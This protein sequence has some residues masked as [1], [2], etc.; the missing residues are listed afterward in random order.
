MSLQVD[1]YSKIATFQFSIFQ[2]SNCYNPP[3]IL[4]ERKEIPTY[5]LEVTVKKPCNNRGLARCIKL[6]MHDIVHL[7]WYH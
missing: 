2:F 4:N 3:D 6:D 5:R 1:E 7:F